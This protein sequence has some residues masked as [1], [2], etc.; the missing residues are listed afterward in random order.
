MSIWQS[1]AKSR[2]VI[3]FRLAR[4]SF[5]D[6]TVSPPRRHW[7]LLSHLRRH[8]HRTLRFDNFRHSLWWPAIVNIYIHFHYHLFWV[9]G[10]QPHSRAHNQVGPHLKIISIKSAVSSAGRSIVTIA[11]FLLGDEIDFYSL[12]DLRQDTKVEIK[13]IVEELSLFPDWWSRESHFGFELDFKIK[14]SQF[15]QLKNDQLMR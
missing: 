4:V 12:F 9:N 13:N 1:H 2:T 3:S 11:F 7:D 8:I 5:N 15:D 10:R 14:R 6:V